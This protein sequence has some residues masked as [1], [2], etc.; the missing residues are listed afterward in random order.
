MQKIGVWLV[1]IVAALIALLAV[2]NW[3]T[4]NMPTTVDLLITQVQ[5][6][7]GLMM[8]GLSAGLFIVFLLM[9]LRTHIGAMLETRKLLAEV[10]RLQGLADRAEASRMESLQV[11]IAAEFRQ[12]NE[13]LRNAPAGQLPMP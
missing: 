8:L 5:A 3:H 10:Q 9:T 11:F 7:L 13:R 2:A 4:L 1:A 12:L 6:P